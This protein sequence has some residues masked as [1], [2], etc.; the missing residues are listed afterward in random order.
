VVKAT[1]SALRGAV[2][3]IRSLMSPVTAGGG[4]VIAVVLVLC[5]AGALLMFPLGIFFSGEDSG[6]GLTMPSVVREIN[7][8][9]NDRVE[10]LKTGAAYD[11]VSLSGSRAVWSEVLAVYAVKTAAD[12]TNG[13]DVVSIDGAKKELLKQPVFQPPSVNGT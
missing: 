10:A 7:Q 6:S 13:Q 3:A 9:Y 1:A 4:A 8:E 2:S 11:A 12:P 5:L